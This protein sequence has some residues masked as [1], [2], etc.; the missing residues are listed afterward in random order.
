MKY[1]DALKVWGAN[2][3]VERNNIH[4]N[5][6]DVNSVSVS[7]YFNE[8]YNCC[9]G[10]DPLCYCSFAESPSASVRVEA[11]NV[12]SSQDSRIF[13]WTQD[14]EDFSFTEVLRELCEI[15]GSISS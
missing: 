7:F 15:D 2:K 3:V 1:E 14:V 10:S 5:D 12:G 6:I 11:K 4:L 13:S 9:G 8:G